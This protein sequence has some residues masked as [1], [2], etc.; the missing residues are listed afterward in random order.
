MPGEA[1]AAIGPVIAG[2]TI[3]AEIGAGAAAVVY[4]ALD[5]PN[6]RRVAI[7]VLRPDSDDSVRERFVHECTSAARLKHQNIVSVFDVGTFEDRPFMVMEYIDGRPLDLHRPVRAVVATLIK[8]AHALESVHAQGIVHRDLKPGNIL[9]DARGEPHIVDFGLA[10][11]LDSDA[12]ITRRG[13]AVGTPA[14]MAPEQV[15]GWRDLIGPCTDVYAM[16]AM[17]YEALAGK[18]AHTGKHLTEVVMSIRKKDPPPPP[19]PKALV[20]ICMKAMSRTIAKR[21]ARAGALAGELEEWL[22][23]EA[24]TRI[25]KSRPK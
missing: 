10:Q 8:V 5:K 24:E 3:E 25:T 19:G 14:Y 11:L 1:E 6:R 4:R 23:A 21:H 20:A 16:G 22:G 18:P 7:K 9:V 15:N 2:Y 13:K 17:L 12:K